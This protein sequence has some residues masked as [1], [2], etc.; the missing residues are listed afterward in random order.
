LNGGIDKTTN[1]GVTWSPLTGAPA[2]IS[3]KDVAISP[4]DP[5]HLYAGGEDFYFQSRLY[6]SR[7]G[8]LTWT[9]IPSLGSPGSDNSVDKVAV[10]PVD[11]SRIH[12]GMEDYTA[13]STNGGSTWSFQNFPGSSFMFS[14]DVVV[15]PL[16]PSRVFYLAFDY[17]GSSSPLHLAVSNDQGA[18]WTLLNYDPGYGHGE[19][20][21]MEVLF[22]GGGTSVYFAGRGVYRVGPFAVSGVSEPEPGTPAVTLLAPFERNGRMVIPY[23]V[24][25]PGTP[26]SF[27][28]YD[29]QGRRV[30]S[31]PTVV[32]DAG[33]Y[34][35]QWSGEDDE[36]HETAVGVFFVRLDASGV[37]VSAKLV[38]SA[39]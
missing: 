22:E 34:E 28:I 15:D 8:G 23:S 2:S 14:F 7:N 37:A 1:G 39:R 29:V 6:E 35:T 24:A 3:W 27:S 4:H 13:L 10:N 33:T 38:R 36:G 32:R 9:G 31:F 16:E 5:E 12:M 11:P 17:W 18:S 19:A 26:V 30:R 25:A 21:D 20:W